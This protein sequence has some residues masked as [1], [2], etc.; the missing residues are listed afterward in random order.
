MSWLDEELAPFA[1][2]FHGFG[3]IGEA[4]AGGMRPARVRVELPIEFYAEVDDDGGVRLIGA[5]PTQHVTTSWMPVWHRIAL[6]VR[7]DAGG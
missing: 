5:P 2:L 7:A 3:D 1:A 4:F 6:E